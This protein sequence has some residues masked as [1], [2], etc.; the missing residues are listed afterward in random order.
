MPFLLTFQ[1]KLIYLLT[2]HSKLSLPLP[3]KTQL[4]LLKTVPIVRTIQPS[5]VKHLNSAEYTVEKVSDFPVSSRDVTNK[6]NIKK[7]FKTAINGLETRYGSGTG[8]VT[9]QKSESEPE[10]LS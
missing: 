6:G 9:C 4:S 7:K 2:A 8:T 10:Q 1:T 5:I 3:L